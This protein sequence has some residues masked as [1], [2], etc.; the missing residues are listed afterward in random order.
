MLDRI[1]RILWDARRFGVAPSKW[2]ARLANRSEPRIVC[3]TVPKSGTHML[4]R[5]LCLHPRL[6]RPVL[7]TIHSENLDR[8]GGLDGLLEG[9]GA[10]QGLVTHLHHAPGRAEALRSS[11]VRTI[12]MTR[13]PRDVVVSRVPY[14]L[15]ETKHVHHRVMAARTDPR[16]RLRLAIE[17]DA[18]SGMPSVAEVLD[19]FAGWLEGDALRIR[20]E[21]LVGAAG[22]GSDAVQRSAIEGLYAHLGMDPGEAELERIRRRLFSASS[23]TFHKGRIGRWRE[24]F[25][26]DLAE[27][28]RRVTGERLQR[29][30]YPAA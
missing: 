13:D 19:R 10:G 8:Y 4:E 22:G 29:Y 20:F 17:G 12:F 30:G 6:Y 14:L 25:D 18:A 21:D 7:P 11:G 26:P 16:E 5:A 3:V 2:H 9:L 28:F 24:L 15:R 27:R 23:P 1:S